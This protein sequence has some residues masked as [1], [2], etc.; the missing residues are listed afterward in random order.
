MIVVGE[1]NGVDNNVLNL[2]WLR[3]RCYQV[4]DGAR[5][6][7]CALIKELPQCC[8]NGRLILS[9]GQMQYFEVFLIGTAIKPSFDLIIGHTEAVRREEV[10][11]V[12]VVLKRPWLT[13]QPV[14]DMPVLDV[15]AILSPLAWQSVNAL[16]PRKVAA[17]YPTAETLYL[18][19]PR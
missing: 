1:Y 2:R 4:C 12:P 15:M 13:H 3:T 16:L 19:Q 11:P 10:L 17:P 7:E 8:I 6:N 9:G 5:C 18:V 14:D